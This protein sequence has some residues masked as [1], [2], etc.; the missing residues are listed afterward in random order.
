MFPASEEHDMFAVEVEGRYRLAHGLRG[1]RH[2]VVY[3]LPHLVKDDLDIR[4]KSTDV[5]VN[6]CEELFV[7]HLFVSFT[8][9]QEGS[10][11][12]FRICKLPFNDNFLLPKGRTQRVVIKHC[13]PQ[14]D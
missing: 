8:I 12:E 4:W 3:C 2:H 11:S 14:L 1:F 9:R 5:F 10:N 6:R 7:C 13:Y